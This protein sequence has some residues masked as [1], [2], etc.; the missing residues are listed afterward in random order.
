M[1]ILKMANEI[2]ENG[3]HPKKLSKLLSEITQ[4]PTKEIYQLL[5]NKK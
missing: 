2:I 4:K 5:L 3:A 1:N